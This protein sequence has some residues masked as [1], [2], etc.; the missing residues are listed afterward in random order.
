M[1]KN[2]NTR[3]RMKQN[4]W[5]NKFVNQMHTTKFKLVSICCFFFLSF[6]VA[7]EHR[8]F[9]VC[10]CC[11]SIIR[12]ILFPL[13]IFPHIFFIVEQNNRA[14]KKEKNVEKYKIRNT[15]S[16]IRKSNIHILCVAAMAW[17]GPNYFFFLY[18][19]ENINDSQYVNVCVYLCV[20]VCSKVLHFDDVWVV[21]F[22]YF[23]IYTYIF[24]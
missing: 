5:T 23:A 18:I 11:C 13:L 16:F 10:C 9:P 19:R 2:F 3:I 6:S 14:A 24:F 12:M 17:M 1:H 21:F 22:P 15:N 7:Q 4:N 8:W 20:F